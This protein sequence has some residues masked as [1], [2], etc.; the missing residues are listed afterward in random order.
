MRPVAKESSDAVNEDLKFVT[1]MFMIF[2]GIALFVGSFIIWN[3]F[4]M[5]VTQR[6]REI[7]LLRA[8]GATRRQVIRSLLLEAL[9]LGVGASAVGVGLGLGVAKGLKLLMDAVG[10]SL[11]STSMQVEPR[12]IV[13]SLLVGTV[14]TV[15]AALV[16]APGDQGAAGRGAARGV[17]GAGNPSK[18][19]VISGLRSARHRSDRDGPHDLVRRRE[20]EAV[21]PVGLLAIIVG[22]IMLLPVAARPL[23]ALIGAPLRMRGLPGELARQNAMRNPRRTASTAAAL[24]IGLTLVVS[25]GVFASSLKASFGTSSGDSTERRPVR[26]PVEL[27]RRRA[28]APRRSRRSR[29]CPG[30]TRSPRPAGAGPVR[31][32]GLDLLLGRPGHRDGEVLNLRLSAGSVSDLGTT[33]GSWWPSPPRRRTAGRSATPCRPSSPRPASTPEGRRHLRQKGWISDDYVI[34][35]AAQTAAAGPQLMTSGLV[36]LDPAPTGRRCRRA[37]RRRWPTTRTPR[38]STRR[39]SRRRPAAS[40]TSCSR[41]SR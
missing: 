2:A 4:T 7:A 35:I 41:S 8:I 22:V 19:R 6:S 26:H 10:F 13:V 23:A 37:S 1:I 38:C 31:R 27:R 40:S 33:T 24:M 18:Q 11:P 28:T 20:H 5:I 39:G 3:T 17:P 12:T 16:P 21:R 30:S 34:S 15:V 25:M 9:L 36:K 32:R 14:V 29:G